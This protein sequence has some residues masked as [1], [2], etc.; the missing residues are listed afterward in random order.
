[1]AMEK[2]VLSTSATVR[3]MPSMAMEPFFDDVAKNGLRRIDEDP[4]TV[5][6]NTPFTDAPHGVHMAAHQV[7]ADPGRELQRPFEIHLHA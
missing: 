4:P 5:P 6:F 7:A 2:P 3:L 1:M